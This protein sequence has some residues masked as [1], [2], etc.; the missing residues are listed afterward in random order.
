MGMYDSINLEMNC[1][2]CGGEYLD[3]QSKDGDC[4][5]STLEPYEVEEFY[6]GCDDCGSWIT[7]KRLPDNLIEHFKERDKLG[8]YWKFGEYYYRCNVSF[9][10]DY[11][12]KMILKREDALVREIKDK[13]LKEE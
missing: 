4:S 5:L 3:F 2:K 10:V 6:T 1:P 8:K 7:F 12:P 11:D 9:N 13:V